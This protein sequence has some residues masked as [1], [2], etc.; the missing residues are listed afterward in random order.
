MKR[1][2]WVAAIMGFFLLAYV[3]EAVANPLKLN[4]PSPYS[5]VQDG[6]Y[7]RYPFTTAIIVIRSLAVFLT[8][9]VI[10]SLFK[11]SNFPKAVTLLILAGLLQLYALQDVATG[12]YTVPLEWA[13]ALALS[14]LLLLIPAV[15]YFISGLAD[16]T[17][18][19]L[20]Q[21][22]VQTTGDATTPK[23][24]EDEP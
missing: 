19:G 14:G 12:A 23:W 24:L 6:Q 17:K 1:E 7:A 10:A 21:S 5:F 15:Y 16:T 20:Q 3:L 13:I 9:L 22:V 11:K 2:Y 18:K 8:P 4:L